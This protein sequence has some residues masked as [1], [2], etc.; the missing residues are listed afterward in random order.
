[1][2]F[3]ERK[4]LNKISE[5]ENYPS[6]HTISLETMDCN[7][8][9]DRSDSFYSELITFS[10]I[11]NINCVSPP[12][13]YFNDFFFNFDCYLLGNTYLKI[14]EITHNENPP[15]AKFLI[16][17]LNHRNRSTL[18][19]IIVQ[20]ITS[21]FI[22]LLSKANPAKWRHRRT[23]FQVPQWLLDAFFFLEH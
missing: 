6:T 8:A 23:V 15:F 21:I 4:Q 5:I 2:L 10:S 12:K 11:S 19:F 7:K 1:M 14:F 16:S 22:I 13:I 9:N 20:G 3:Y 18:S 17:K